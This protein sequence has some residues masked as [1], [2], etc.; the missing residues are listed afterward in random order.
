[1]RSLE[2]GSALGE[3]VIQVGGLLCVRSGLFILRFGFW[4]LNL[5]WCV[6]FGFFYFLV[7][8]ELVF[9]AYGS[10]ITPGSEHYKDPTKLN[11]HQPAHTVLY[12]TSKPFT[13]SFQ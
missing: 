8:M 10:E 11:K 13:F 7:D 9:F 1:M 3:G 4:I 6:S 5:R 2:Q 12:I